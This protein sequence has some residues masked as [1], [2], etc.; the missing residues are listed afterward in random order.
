MPGLPQRTQRVNGGS[1]GLSIIAA[2]VHI[3]G[4]ITTTGE[5][6]LD[7]SVEGDIRCGG[8]I[9]GEGGKLSGTITATTVTIRGT[10][11]GNIFAKTAI[12]ERTCKV[13]GDIVQE[14]ISIEA[15]AHIDGRLIH[16][17]NPHEQLAVVDHVPTLK[18]IG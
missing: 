2:D 18:A 3:S 16:K 9:L 10:V 1:G 12:L 6:Q 7:G 5:L 14:S 8:L 17:Q 13:A 15:G 4:H 11:E